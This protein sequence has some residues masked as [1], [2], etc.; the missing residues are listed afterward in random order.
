MS[1][2]APRILLIEDDLFFQAR[3]LSALKKRGY[4]TETA[5][6]PEDALAKAQAARPALV[7]LNLAAPRLGGL[8]LVRQLKALPDPPRVLTFLSHVLIP[9][10]RDEALAAGADMLCAN[11]AIALRLPD[12]VDEALRVEG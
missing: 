1:E 5:A 7:I 8:D 3:I 6:T 10:V 12:L 11:S 2:T 9:A 4:P